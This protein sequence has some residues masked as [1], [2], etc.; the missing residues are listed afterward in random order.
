MIDHQIAHSPAFNPTLLP[1]SALTMH[2]VFAH[3]HARPRLVFALLLGLLAA[4]LVPGVSSGVTRGLL[5]WNVAVWV[6]LVLVGWMMLQADHHQL[7]RVAVAQAESAVTVLAML[8]AAAVASLVGVVIELSAAKL[9]G[10]SHTLPHVALALATVL[11]AWLLVP[12]MFALTYASRFYQQPHEDR[13]QGLNFPGA[14]DG[15]KPDYSDFLYFSF[16]IAVASQTSDVLITSRA[17]RRVVLL[18]SVLSFVFNTIILAFSIN[19]A[20]S[21]L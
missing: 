16:T 7:R 15:F 6:Y 4:L 9:P 3:V 19:M 12:T 1:C 17:V 21:L 2:P 20:A 10:A 13:G 18:Q 5:G 8:S 11:G 14:V